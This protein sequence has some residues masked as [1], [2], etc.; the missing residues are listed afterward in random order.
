MSNE[1]IIFFI[2]SAIV[3]CYIIFSIYESIK[4]DDDNWLK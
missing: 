1:I 2:I 3:S 4:E